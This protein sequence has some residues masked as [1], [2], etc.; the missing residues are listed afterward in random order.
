M[1]QRFGA[2][3]A[4]AAVVAALAVAAAPVPAA[5]QSQGWTGTG[6]TLE[7]LNYRLGILDAELADIR[8]RIRALSGGTAGRGAGTSSGG[9]AGGGD[10]MV[11]L[12]RL[13]VELRRLTGEIEE[14][15]FRQ[16]RIAEDAARRFGDIEFRLTELEGGD[17]ATLAPTAPLGGV[18]GGGVALAPDRGTGGTGGGG[19]GGGAAA[20]AASPAPAGERADLELAVADIQQGR[21]DQGE[22][23]LRRFLQDYPQS[24]RA[25]DANFWLGRSHFV[26]GSFAEA[27]QSHLAGYNVDR[28]GPMAAR[29]LLQL[30]ITLGRL[31]QLSE[32]CLTLREVRNQFPG[33]DREILNAA[34]AERDS[35][36]CAP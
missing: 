7:D 4:A 9:F 1:R 12:D 5:A 28:Q 35:L 23:R 18:D 8:A 24:P 3:L 19:T 31:G 22:G 2:G 29:N 20:P 32:A 11:R 26:R 30:G 21:F 14:L 6:E 10:A 25:A 16:R 15:G 36:A 17:P 27:A 34:D 33:A 13:E